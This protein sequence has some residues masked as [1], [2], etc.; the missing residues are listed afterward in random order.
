MTESACS[1]PAQEPAVGER[2][3]TAVGRV[4]VEPG[5]ALAAQRC[6]LVERV[7]RAGVR[8]SGLRRDGERGQ[9]SLLVRVHRGCERPGGEPEGLVARQHAHLLRPKAQDPRGARDRGMRLVGDVEHE[10]VPHRAGAALARASQGGQVPGRAAADERAGC[11]GRKP[12]PVLEPAEHLELDLARAGRLHPRARVEVAGTGDQVTEGAGPGSGEGDEAEE[13]RVA[14][15]A[16]EREDVA[17]EAGEDLVERLRLVGWGAVEPVAHLCRRGAADR[18]LGTMQPIDQQVDR[19][20]A[21]LAH[22]LGIE[23]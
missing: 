10:V 9:A 23:R 1:S 8:R 11:V 6:E 13:A 18:R 15:A 21:N 5:P 17:V 7:D 14:V 22:R 4:H 2:R 20:V 3:E 12:D 19:A 16:G